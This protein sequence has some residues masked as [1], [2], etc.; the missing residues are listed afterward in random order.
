MIKKV[1]NAKSAPVAT[2]FTRLYDF[3]D[4]RKEGVWGDQSVE[5]DDL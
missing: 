2:A 3:A 1:K 4:H 5:I